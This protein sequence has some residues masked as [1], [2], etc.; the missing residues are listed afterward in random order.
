[1]LMRVIPTPTVAFAIPV[2]VIALTVACV[3]DGTGLDENGNLL[4]TAEPG[5]VGSVTFSADVQPIFTANC[6]LSGCHAGSAPAMG[7]NLSEGVAYANIVGVPSREVPALNR[8]EPDEPDGSYLIHK[9]QDTQASVGGFGGRM[10]LGGG[11]LSDD[12]IAAIRAWVA[13]GA[14]NN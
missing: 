1:M 10:P 7:Q 5:P 3:G 6:A 8:I 13:Q 14:P 11:A 4:G 9:I 2:V 12:E